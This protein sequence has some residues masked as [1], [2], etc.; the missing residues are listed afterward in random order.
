MLSHGLCKASLPAA[1][2]RVLLLVGL[3]SLAWKRC[4]LTFTQRGNLI[5]RDFQV[6]NLEKQPLK[7]LKQ[8]TFTTVGSSPPRRLQACIEAAVS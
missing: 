6:S 7:K 4:P 1:S 3:G 5:R 2:L 8:T